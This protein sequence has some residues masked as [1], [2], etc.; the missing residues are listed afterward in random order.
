MYVVSWPV[1]WDLPTLK[2]K[3]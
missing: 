3:N 1:L 2:A